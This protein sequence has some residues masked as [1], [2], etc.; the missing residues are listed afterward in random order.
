MNMG[1]MGEAMVDGTPFNVLM[2]QAVKLKTHVHKIDRV[3]FDA[4]PK[5]YQN[6][7]FVKDEH[8]K[9]RTLAFEERMV[10]ARA[11]KEKGD[12]AFREGK[13]LEACNEYEACGGL[14]KWATTLREP[15]REPQRQSR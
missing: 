3:R 12:A 7:A 15:S 9:E 8:K 5:F 13:M 2:Q 14:F 1:G 10:C 11:Y 6:T 4:W